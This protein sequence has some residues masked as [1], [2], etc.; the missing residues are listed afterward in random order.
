MHLV[1]LI[2]SQLVLLF[3]ISHVVSVVVGV[4]IASETF[5]LP[6]ALTRFLET[7]L[8]SFFIAGGD[9]HCFAG[10]AEG[11]S[12]VHARRHC[13]VSAPLNAIAAAWIAGDGVPAD[14]AAVRVWCG[15]GEGGE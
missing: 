12:A 2:I 13:A 11:K 3:S 9:D 14:G 7:V 8:P 4:M 5:I 10:H 1:S 6:V 15:Q